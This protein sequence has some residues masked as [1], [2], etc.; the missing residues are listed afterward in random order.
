MFYELPRSTKI[1]ALELFL[2]PI[3]FTTLVCF[4]G[5]MSKHT[6]VISESNEI[7]KR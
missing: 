2:S 6:Q 4:I 3:T 1:I 5:F 7:V